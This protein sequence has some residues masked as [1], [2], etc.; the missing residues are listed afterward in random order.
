MERA[1]LNIFE[2][3]AESRGGRPA[4]LGSSAGSARLR[5]EDRRMLVEELRAI[6]AT[7]PDLPAD[8][9]AQHDHYIHGTSKRS[10]VILK[11]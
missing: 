11:G 2:F 7:M 3:P 9:A 1:I 6:A 4:A 10:S 8:W 5:S